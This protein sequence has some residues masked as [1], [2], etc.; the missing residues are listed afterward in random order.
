MGQ[1]VAQMHE[2]YMMMMMRGGIGLDESLEFELRNGSDKQAKG[3]CDPEQSI[4][5]KASMTWVGDMM[6]VPQ[7]L[8]TPCHIP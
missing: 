8:T 5:L 1:Q 3:L 2:S 7:L 6:A 4:W